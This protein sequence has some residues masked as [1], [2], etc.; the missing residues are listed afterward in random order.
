MHPE[1]VAGS[2]GDGVSAVE[3]GLLQL[4]VVEIS[5]DQYERLCTSSK[6]LAFS[7]IVD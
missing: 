5:V 1:C 4:E 3:A 2:A 6:M 7:C